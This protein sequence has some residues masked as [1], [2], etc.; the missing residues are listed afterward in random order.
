MKRW[1]V[2]LLLL[3]LPLTMAPRT[4]LN[5][6]GGDLALTGIISRT[7]VRP[8]SAVTFV[9]QARNTTG[10]TLERAQVNIFVGWDGKSDALTLVASRACGTEAV[11]SGWLVTCGLVDLGADEQATLRV[12]ARPLTAGELTFH[13]T[14]GGGLAPEPAN[15][16]FHVTVGGSG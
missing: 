14:S 4:S 6:D 2:V 15:R 8:G 1:T 10:A 3:L 11:E 13:A 7:Q 12:T 9:V 5:P 16:T